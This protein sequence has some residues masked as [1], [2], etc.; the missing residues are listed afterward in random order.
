[1]KTQETYKSFNSNKSIEELQYNISSAISI[2]ENLSLELEFY[3][4][5]LDKPIY[6]KHAINLYERLTNYKNEIKGINTKRVNLL[7][8]LYSHTNHIKIKI[9]C[10]DLACDNYF[11]KE[12]E[13][14]ELKIFGFYNALSNFKFKLFQYLESVLVN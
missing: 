9:E 13:D 2:L 7:N 6:K 12:H 8:E 14:I 10:E 4:H 5:L 1:M 3:E 11:V